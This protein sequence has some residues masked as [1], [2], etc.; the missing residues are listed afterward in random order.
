[1]GKPSRSHRVVQIDDFPAC[2]IGYALRWWRDDLRGMTLQAAAQA[3]HRDFSYL[4]RWE[5]AER[6]IPASVIRELDELYGA[7]GRLVSLAAILPELHRYPDSA[8]VAPF[9]RQ[10]GR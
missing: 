5:R 4:A 2:M 1:M 6:P 10:R 3:I 7:D 9:A 8:E